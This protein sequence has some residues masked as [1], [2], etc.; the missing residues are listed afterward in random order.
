MR[1]A[2]LLG[3]A[4]LG[5]AMPATTQAGTFPDSHDPVTPDWGGPVFRLSQQFPQTDPSKA[6]P[7][8]TY[9]WQQIDF[10]VQPASA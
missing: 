9:P 2:I 6:T 8:P 1:R 4:F 10:R 5:L 7:A 3:A